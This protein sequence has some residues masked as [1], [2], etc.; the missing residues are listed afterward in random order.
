MVVK[1]M[2][3]E[4]IAFSSM[5]ILKEI[6]K[7]VHLITIVAVLII[8]SAILRGIHLYGFVLGEAVS[9][10]SKVLS[11]LLRVCTIKTKLQIGK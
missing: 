6:S 8:R 1:R 11:A 10:V 5:S 9:T 3:G 7:N 4:I 2:L